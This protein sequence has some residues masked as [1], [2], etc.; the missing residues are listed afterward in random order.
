MN[1][2]THNKYNIFRTDNL[3]RRIGHNGSVEEGARTRTEHKRRR[4]W[5]DEDIE[6]PK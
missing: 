3:R 1:M 5:T 6:M 4:H 2:E